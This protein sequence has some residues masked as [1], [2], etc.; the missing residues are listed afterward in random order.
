MARD[1]RR[2][3]STQ[4]PLSEIGADLRYAHDGRKEAIHPAAKAVDAENAGK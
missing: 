1:R 2:S 4:G 3:S